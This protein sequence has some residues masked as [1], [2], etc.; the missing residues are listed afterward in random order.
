MSSL[1]NSCPGIHSTRRRLPARA[2][3]AL[4]AALLLPVL[5]GAACAGDGGDSQTRVRREPTRTTSTTVDSP[6]D[7]SSPADA[8]ETAALL[9]RVETALRST[10]T[11][12]ADAARLGW[13]Q[14]LGYR[15]LRAHAEWVPAVLAAIP[16]EV[17]PVVEANERAGRGLATLAEPQPQ[18]PDWRIEAPPAP[19]V[20]VGHYREAESA[21]GIAWPYLAAIHFVETRMGRI[22]GAS[23]AGAQ[24]PMQFLPSTWAA[25]GEGDINDPRAAIVAAGRY[26]AASGGPEDMSRALYAYNHSLR[27]VDAVQTYAGVIATGQELA[28]RGYYHWQVYYATTSGV[29]L[30]PEGYPQ[31]EAVRATQ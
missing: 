21:T 16:V 4:R 5:L 28:Y 26:L 30:L 17:R 31:R 8:T 25:Y 12:A 2:I 24:G 7:L 9:A 10:T 19:E 23:T 27:Y 6:D 29:V 1:S 11:P 20:L 15:T 22:R 3:R 18:L 13:E 14:Q